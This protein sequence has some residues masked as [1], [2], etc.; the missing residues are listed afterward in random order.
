[1]SFPPNLT[2]H[3]APSL[4]TCHV[5]NPRTHC[6]GD[7]NPEVPSALAN[8][9]NGNGHCGLSRVAEPDVFPFVKPRI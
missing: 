5:K 2:N 6:L 7:R 3:N 4:W 9:K 8:L 1:V